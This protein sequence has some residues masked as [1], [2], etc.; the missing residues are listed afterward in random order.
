MGNVDRAK[1]LFQAAAHAPE[2]ARDAL[3]RA[4]TDDDKLVRLTAAVQLAGWHLATLPDAVAH[5]ML[6]TLLVER[7]RLHS[8]PPIYREYFEVTATDDDVH[9]LGQDLAQAI[10]ELPAGF[11][12]VE[13]WRQDRQFYDVALATIALAFAPTEFA[14]SSPE[15]TET[16]R[17]VLAALLEDE[18][19]WSLCGDTAPMLAQRGLPANRDGMWAFLSEDVVSGGPAAT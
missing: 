19:I 16:Q 14:R 5:E 4:L 10:A 3:L 1:E 15:L 17:R 8:E 9:D 6:D 2:A 7:R 13:L 12:L 11:P 18:P